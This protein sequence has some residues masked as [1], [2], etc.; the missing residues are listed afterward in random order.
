MVDK[1]N[2][3]KNAAKKT[4]TGTPA[5]ENAA[6]SAAKSAIEN[7]AVTEDELAGRRIAGGRDTEATAAEAPEFR[8]SNWILVQAA[9]N[10]DHAP[11]GSESDNRGEIGPHMDNVEIGDCGPWF[12][13]NEP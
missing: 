9:A 2:G 7:I 6:K 10:D 1:T 8:Y 11:A 5:A 13:A 12:S 4:A 3:R